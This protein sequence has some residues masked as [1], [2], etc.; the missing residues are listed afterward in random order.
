MKL[1][2]VEWLAYVVK[3]VN[4]ESGSTVK[5][6]IVGYLIHLQTRVSM[7]SNQLKVVVQFP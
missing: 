3:S 1:Y 4:N 5:E 2:I 7:T 6:A